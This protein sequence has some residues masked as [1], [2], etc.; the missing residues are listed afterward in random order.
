MNGFATRLGLLGL[1]SLAVCGRTTSPDDATAKAGAQAKTPEIDGARMRAALEFLA[2]DDM[3]GRYTLYPADIGRAAQYLVDTYRKAGIAPVTDDYLMT[4]DAVA[5]TRVSDDLAVWL[6]IDHQPVEVASGDA[7][8]VANGGGTPV[9]AGVVF[10]G[11]ADVPSTLAK[12]SGKIA[13]AFA[14]GTEPGQVA[15][16]VAAIREAGAKGA[17][18]ALP[19]LASLPEPAAIRAAIA[20]ASMPAVL[21]RVETLATLQIDGESLSSLRKVAEPKARPIPDLQV[22]LA[23][24]REDEMIAA[25]NVLAYLPGTDLAREIVVVG[26]HFDHI[27]T[28]DR[29]HFCRPRDLPD[30]TVDNVCNGADDNGS[31]TVALQEIA[32][33][34]KEAGVHPRR[35]IVFAHFSGEELGL[36]GSKALAD[37]P[38]DAAPFAGGR[39]VAMV[40]MD[41]VGRLGAAG[42]SVGA[43]S[44]SD[45]WLPILEQT[46]DHGLE[47][48]YERAVTARSDHANF[49]RKDIPVLFFFTGLHDDY[50][51]PGDE[52][53]AINFDGMQEITELAMEVTLAAADGRPMEFSSP[54]SGDEGMTNR[55]P[56][57]DPA[58]LTTPGD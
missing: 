55:L 21:M 13:L 5:G 14:A 36:Y 54:R 17:V 8:A 46:G 48:I 51:G 19:E 38:P 3:R 23:A 16:Q 10:V 53:A 4:Y 56:G 33:A 24:R 1:L 9:V 57:T 25:P 39:V 50:H 27:G 6:E 34:L 49:Y 40:N 58:T 18:L 45:A 37:H 35:S 2:S 42:L 31:G 22:S 44:S 12:A 7:V 15:A 32:L 47:I 29:G 41:M 11:A 26:A 30:G 20:D 28:S 43:I 52:V